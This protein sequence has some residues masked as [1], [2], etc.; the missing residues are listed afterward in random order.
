M[1]LVS[2]IRYAIRTLRRTPGF[3]VAAV[4]TFALGAAG[5]T[6]IFSF[7]S[8]IVFAE[9]P[10]PESR[11]VVVV[12]PSQIKDPA[13]VGF[14]ALR[15]FAL[16]RDQDSGLESL[17]LFK[18]VSSAALTGGGDAER[19]QQMQVSPEFFRVLRTTPMLGRWPDA[20]EASEARS[21]VA[22]IT[23]TLWRRRFGADPRVL[24]STIRLNDKLYTV[25]G[26]SAGL[27]SFSDPDVM[28]PLVESAY[29]RDAEA[30]LF[31]AVGRL[32]SG[33]SPHDAE[34]ALAPAVETLRREHPKAWQGW[35]LR[36]QT[37]QDHLIGETRPFLFSLMGAVAFVLLIACANLA[38]LMLARSSGRRQEA[39]IR[40][41]LGATRW[42][43]LR[44][45]VAEMAIIALVGSAAAILVASWSLDLLKRVAPW[46]LPH[47]QNVTIDARVLLF[48]MLVGLV[49][50]VI[51]GLV[52]ALVLPD[53]ST[54]RALRAGR[55]RRSRGQQVLAASQL[56]LCVVL[57]VGATLMI[58]TMMH[59]NAL[60]LGFTI[61]NV[62]RFR[63]AL[64]VSRYPDLPAMQRF[65]SQVQDELS[66]SA[67]VEAAGAVNL[68]PLAGPGGTMQFE[69][70]GAPPPSPGEFARNGTR[71]AQSRIVDGDYFRVLGIPL[72]AGRALGPR[73]RAGA[74]CAVVVN[75]RFLQAFGE[76]ANVVGRSVRGRSRDSVAPLCEIVGI[77]GDVR[78]WG[79]KLP[80]WPEIYYSLQQIPLS[81]GGWA[82]QMTFV[83]R[84]RSASAEA[85]T[86]V[87][88]AVQRVDKD[89]PI[90]DFAALGELWSK[91]TARE[92]FTALLLSAFAGLSLFLAALGVY[93]LLSWAVSQRSHE[94]GI[95]MALGATGA[96]VARLIA[97]QVGYVTL[98]GLL[99][100]VTASVALSRVLTALLFGVAPHEPAT[101]AVVALA[102]LSAA[103]GAALLP[104]RRA[105]SVDPAKVL[106]RDG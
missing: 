54:E 101:Y 41:S 69:L 59:L 9:L 87:R 83:S 91:A 28:T 52:P 65:A 21:D 23:E 78:H 95:R 15:E 62:F 77:V 45:S 89:Q 36:V 79:H 47:V 67:H 103:L 44:H 105:S 58:R 49:A 19:V 29:A 4:L 40:L 8:G 18:R 14:I 22:V 51:T 81:E 6:A 92:R 97:A 63:T 75:E 26:V 98:A 3:A 82:R 99:V 64:P 17:A 2:D 1:G 10:F 93:A 27:P 16:W 13:S 38:G 76:G 5:N 50:G 42:A 7:L 57:L 72:L 86:T 96:H 39:A 20:T 25:I 31:G 80:I 104:A 11:R 90:H 88:A 71:L 85:M 60:P 74:P 84:M 106:R 12:H 70:V 32:R 24:G 46:D 100:G 53:T 33:V 56:A 30:T 43:L 102:L 73:D 61:D 34:R 55:F 48:T 35:T 94:F 37:L 68:L 66:R